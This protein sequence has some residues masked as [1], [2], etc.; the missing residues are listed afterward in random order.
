[1]S[2]LERASWVSDRTGI[3]RQG[4]WALVRA[5]RLPVIRVGRRYLFDPMKIDEWLA[6]GGEARNAERAPA[7]GHTT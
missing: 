6:A 7:N 2:R 3:P 5:G 1:M 4:I